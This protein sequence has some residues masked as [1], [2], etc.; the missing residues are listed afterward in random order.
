[1]IEPKTI[2]VTWSGGLDSTYTLIKDL[3]KGY[4]VQPIYIEFKSAGNDKILVEKDA[5]LKMHEILKLKFSNL[6]KPHFIFTSDMIRDKDNI[7]YGGSGLSIPIM[8]NIMSIQPIAWILGISDYLNQMLE[9]IT[10][11]DIKNLNNNLIEYKKIKEIQMGYVLNDDSISILDI[12]QNLYKILNNFTISHNVYGIDYPKLIFPSIKIPKTFAY[13]Y[14]KENYNELKTY[15]TTCEK[16]IILINKEEKIFY[17][18]CGDCGTCT[19]I[20]QE[21]SYDYNVSSIRE[22]KYNDNNYTKDD[23]YCRDYDEY[24]NQQNTKVSVRK[25]VKEEERK[26]I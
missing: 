3:E 1:V 21:L 23:L 17:K 16:P 5:I 25:L 10:Y 2:I 8:N 14:I 13:F 22:I 9:K 11:N 19:H 4:I 20:K 12:I 6:R 26:A 18:Q 24:I 15:I 7:S